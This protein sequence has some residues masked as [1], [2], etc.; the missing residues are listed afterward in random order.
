MA[1]ISPARSIGITYLISISFSSVILFWHPRVMY[2]SPGRFSIRCVA[3]SPSCLTID[4]TMHR[5]LDFFCS[6]SR[7]NKSMP[8]SAS[9]ILQ[10]YT[11]ASSAA[12]G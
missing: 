11:K 3:T 9:P 12:S 4:A 10:K 8:R 2:M 1:D 6:A 5:N 7:F